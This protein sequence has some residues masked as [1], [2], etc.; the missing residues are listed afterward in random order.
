M[1]AECSRLRSEVEACEQGLADNQSGQL[2]T[3][4]HRCVWRDELDVRAGQL[5]R[6]SLQFDATKRSLDAANEELQWQA[7]SAEALRMRLADVQRAIKGE[8]AKTSELRAEHRQS[9]NSVEALLQHWSQ[10]R[11]DNAD[12]AEV[13][14][15]GTAF[16][17]TSAM[18]L[19]L[20]CQ[21]AQWLLESIRRSESPEVQVDSSSAGTTASHAMGTSG[22]G[23]EASAGFGLLQG[24]LS[25][26]PSTTSLTTAGASD[27]ASAIMAASR[28]STAS[29]ST[30]A[31]RGA[32]LPSGAMEAQGG[33]VRLSI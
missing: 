12:E 3:W 9:Q 32:R 7:T 31:G 11:D 2:P 23:S 8:E 13:G 16:G 5:E 15:G 14:F 33:S 27:A 26:T 1:E 24:A 21:Q 4:A 18:A 20:V 6:I 25:S 30:V 10:P 28:S 22:F 29:Q 19:P 17:S